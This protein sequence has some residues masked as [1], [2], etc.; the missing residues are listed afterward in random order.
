MCLLAFFGWEESS[1][2]QQIKKKKKSTQ[3][4]TFGYLFPILVRVWMG[5]EAMILSL[6]GDWTVLASELP[7]E[8]LAADGT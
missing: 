5:R 3:L 8:Q 2:V 6:Q 7:A 1:G 4:G